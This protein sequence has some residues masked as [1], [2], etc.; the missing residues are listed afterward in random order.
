MNTPM[1]VAI[2][3]D[4]HVRRA[5]V[6]VEVD[7]YLRWLS[8][9]VLAHRN[10]AKKLFGIGGRSGQNAAAHMALYGGVPRSPR[11]TE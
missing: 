8:W 11:S 1:H 4:A 5:Q 3:S 9:P 6:I 7:D 2:I 10:R